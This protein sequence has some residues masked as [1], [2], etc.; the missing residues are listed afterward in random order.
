MLENLRGQNST[1]PLHG[2]V[3]VGRGGADVVA[4]AVPF[5]DLVEG[6]RPT[7]AVTSG[8]VVDEV[9]VEFC[10]L[11]ATVVR[12]M[13]GRPLEKSAEYKEYALVKVLETSVVVSVVLLD[14]GVFEE[15][16]EEDCAFVGIVN[17]ARGKN[18][19]LRIMRAMRCERMSGY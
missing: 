4:D 18:N 15:E 19:N 11:E 9:V 10:R 3:L 13:P 5:E 12:T 2:R 6:D 16:K 7:T 8:V 1:Y 17:R 14:I